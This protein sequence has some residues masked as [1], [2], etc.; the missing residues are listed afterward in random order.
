M[1][2]QYA[3]V[4]PHKGS[5]VY[6]LVYELQPTDLERLDKQEA[7]PTC[8]GRE[9]LEV[10]I[11]R[12]KS[13]QRVDVT[14]K[15]QKEKAIVYID[16]DNTE[17]DDPRPEYVHRMNKGI[18]DALAMG[19]PTSYVEK[20]M[21]PF[22][23]DIPDDGLDDRKAEAHEI[24]HQHFHDAL[25]KVDQR[26]LDNIAERIEEQETR[27]L[28]MRRQSASEVVHEHFKDTLPKLDAQ[29]VEDIARRVSEMEARDLDMRKE[30]A[31][32]LVHEHFKDALP[33]L[34]EQ[35]VED[36]ARRVSEMESR[37]IDMRKEEAYDIVHQHFS[38]SLPKKEA[39]I[40][41]DVALRMKEQEER[42][43]LLLVQN[44]RGQASAH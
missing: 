8:Y 36:I 37:D 42:D 38:S 43:K 18:R 2:R 11:W 29:V 39:Y 16:Y 21:R 4:V 24:V 25:P 32:E 14:K 23:P 10:D 5:E 34:D 1:E 33:K 27:N 28:Q 40:I 6:G 26:V 22:I 13:K 30:E 35:V 44:E 3:N 12:S 41:E 19:V 7:F 20:T 17:D 9:P 15:T 31:Y